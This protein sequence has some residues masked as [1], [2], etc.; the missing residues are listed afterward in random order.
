MPT[1]SRYSSPRKRVELVKSVTRD[2]S[3]VQ[4][5]VFTGLGCR[6]CSQHWRPG[7]GSRNQTADR[8][9]WRIHNDDGE[10]PA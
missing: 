6:F 5:E 7:D 2:L 4:V 10:S 1:R 9:R 3:N 8:Y